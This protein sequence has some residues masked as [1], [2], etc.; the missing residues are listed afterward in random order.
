MVHSKPRNATTETITVRNAKHD[1]LDSLVDLA[2]RSFRDAF[3]SENAKHDI[4]AYIDSAFTI[5]KFKAEFSTANNCFLVANSGSSDKPLGYAKLRVNSRTSSVAGDSCV[6]LERLY[7]DSTVTGE[8]IGA[9]LMRE[10][11]RRAKKIGCD[12]IWL[13]VWERNARAIR[14]YE[15]HGF[16]VVGEH[17]FTLGSDIQNDLIMCKSLK[18]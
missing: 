10:C 9:A 1:D 16:N 11:V 12:T 2:A 18:E 14:F 4:D 7:A 13:G 15:R 6:E 17:E 3:A 8:G 5:G